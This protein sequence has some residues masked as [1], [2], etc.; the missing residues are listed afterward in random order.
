MKSIKTLSEWTICIGLAVALAGCGGPS[1]SRRGDDPSV[2]GTSDGQSQ[3]EEVDSQGELK[4]REVVA[5]EIKYVP[6]VTKSAQD[7]F[8][9]G[10]ILVYESPANATAE[11]LAEQ[12]REA[13]G[14][15]QEAIDD[16]PGFL[17]AYFNLGMMYERLKE[18][19]KALEIFRKAAERSKTREVELRSSGQQAEDETVRATK[20]AATAEAYMAKIL[21]RNAEDK[22]MLGNDYDAHKDT[23]DARKMLDK[24][25]LRDENNVAGNN[26]MAL[27]WLA[28]N[29]LEQ[30]EEHVKS[31]LNIEPLNTAA[32]NTRGLINYRNKEYRIAKWIFLQKVIQIDK[33]STEAWTNLGL[34]HLALDDK[35][36]AVD[37]FA[38]AAKL[39]PDNVPARLNL[40]AIYLDYLNYPAARDLYATVI[41]LD[42]DNV[43]AMIGRGTANWGLGAVDETV[44]DYERCLELTDRYP[45]L[46]KRLGGIYEGRSENDKAIAYYEKYILAANIP[47]TDVLVM[48]VA[49]LKDP[50]FGLEEPKG[51]DGEDGFDDFE[52][53]DDEGNAPEAPAP[54][55]E[56][57]A[58]AEEAPAPAEEAPAPAEEAPAP[59][60]E[61]P[62]PAEETPAPASEDAPAEEASTEE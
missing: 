12:Y 1:S 35:P 44:A 53:M 24:V 16:D 41:L 42:D 19:D 51:P 36:R 30:A 58:P 23:D 37:A 62:A 47:L 40:A 9:K 57:P 18:T 15:F 38:K 31:V 5:I 60:E 4:R 55:E 43:E 45:E 10:L 33:N 6:D 34:T 21:L 22:R 29:N 20:N 50:T 52:D 11:E 8:Q 59:A 26:A 14:K 27:Y 2:D 3:A 17:E 49:V 48:K 28:E 32:L 7:T 13:A 46:L 39:D 56:A 54:A 61:A 25:L